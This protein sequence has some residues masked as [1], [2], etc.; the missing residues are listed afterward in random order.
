M[1]IISIAGTSSETG[2]TTVG[3]F[4][5]KALGD[6]SALKITVRHEGQCPRHKDDSC[7]GCTYEENTLF[8]IVID[9][10][11]L[12]E[13]GKDTARYIKAGAPRVVWLQTNSEC[14]KEGT[15]RAL[16]LFGD[17]AT[18]LI[19]GN[20][21]LAVGDADIAIMVISPDSEK[22]KRSAMEVFGKIDLF[23]INKRPGHREELIAS[24]KA[25]LISMGCKVP[26]IVLDPYNP[27]PTAQDK[28]IEQIKGA[29]NPPVGMAL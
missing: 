9:P 17:R 2:K 1:K 29:L 3:A 19:E 5:I 6:I 12:A 27:E 23:V 15:R 8:R 18:V 11:I 16:R 22:I 28:L 25:R 7:D 21:F 20:R 26:I 10:V 13:T 14:A 24:T 4:I